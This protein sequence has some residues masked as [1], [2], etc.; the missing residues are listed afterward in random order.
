[1]LKTY[2]IDRQ[3]ACRLLNV[4]LRTVD[5]YLATGKLTSV[6]NRGRVWL[7]KNEIIRIA[8]EFE[9]LKNDNSDSDDNVIWQQDSTVKTDNFQQIPDENI[10]IAQTKERESISDIFKNESFSSDNQELEKYKTL[11]QEAKAQLELANYKLAHL[12]SQVQSMVPLLEFQKKQQQLAETAQSYTK[13]INEIE[14]K[15]K[16]QAKVLLHKIEEKEQELQTKDQEV[17]T[18]RLNKAV[19]AVILFFILIMQPILWILLK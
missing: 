11:Y 14:T 3:T 9:A 19:F 12:E 16:F 17:S 6:K 5:R 2:N 10:V 15:M 13:K 8:Q 4:S 1:M 18:E 7:S